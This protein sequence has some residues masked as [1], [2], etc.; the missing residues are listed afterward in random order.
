MANKKFTTP[1]GLV[2]ST[3]PDLNLQQNDQEVIT[4]PQEEQKLFVST[5]KKNRGGKV[6]SVISGYSGKKTDLEELGKLIRSH[7]GSGGTEKEN[8]IIIQGDHKEKI[9][10]WLKQKGY[11]LVKKI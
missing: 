1:T 9:V 2:Y 5:D 7:C 10:Q 8:E 4:L 6:V 3:N 11:S